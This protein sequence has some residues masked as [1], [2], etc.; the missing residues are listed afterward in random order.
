M[1][2]KDIKGQATFQ[3]PDKK[4]PPMAP[5]VPE[6]VTNPPPPPNAKRRV[7]NLKMVDGEWHTFPKDEFNEV[8]MATGKD[9]P[10]PK[11]KQKK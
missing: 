8:D 4:P 2:D 1:K 7:F 3:E 10:P 11:A 6:W 5:M 9:L